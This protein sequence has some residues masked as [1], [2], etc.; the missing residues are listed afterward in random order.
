MAM[1]HVV[2]E[3]VTVVRERLLCDCGGELIR[4][5]GGDLLSKP[6]QYPHECNKCGA[7][8]Y[9]RGVSY[10]RIQARSEKYI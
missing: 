1:P 8:Q 7:Q 3:P 5:D 2:T 10:P 4:T 6:P 9:V